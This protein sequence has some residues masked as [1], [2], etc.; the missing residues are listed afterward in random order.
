MT[1]RAACLLVAALVVTG[2]PASIPLIDPGPQTW[3]GRLECADLK[4]AEC[5]AAEAAVIDSLARFGPFDLTAIGIAVG[6]EAACPTGLPD[7]GFAAAPSRLLG[8]ATV[9]FEG[10]RWGYTNI[11]EM[12]DGRVI[13]DAV[14][15]VGP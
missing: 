3:S 5:N 8:H 2:C 6:P 4:P 13:A 9:T 1:L 14:T 11:K 12:P 15:L 10:G 7:C